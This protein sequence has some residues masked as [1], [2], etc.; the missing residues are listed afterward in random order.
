MKRIGVI[1]GIGP[2][3]TVAYY[4]LLIKRYREEISPNHYPEFLLHSIDMTQML[5]FVF[6]GRLEELTSFLAERVKLLEDAGAEFVALASNTPHLVYDNLAAAV[7]VEMISIVEETCKAMATSGYKKVG[8]LGTKSTMSM[9][10][11]QG[12]GLRNGI[13]IVT[14]AEAE[15]NYVHEKYMGELVFNEIKPSTKSRLISVVEEMR[16]QHRIEGVILGGTE[17]PLILEQA[18]FEDLKVFNTT[19]I[20][21]NALLEKMKT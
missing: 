5:D 16:S 14:P 19:E 12:V 6:S 1:G 3:S 4:R 11:Y 17:L 9:G 20:H 21:V 13:E 15:Q 2:E 7:Q 8:L 18:A 10:F